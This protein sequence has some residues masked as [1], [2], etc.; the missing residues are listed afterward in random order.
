MIIIRQ[1]EIFKYLL[2]LDPK[3]DF[4]FKIFLFLLHNVN[5]WL[6]KK[7]IN[8]FTSVTLFFELICPLLVEQEFTH[9]IFIGI[10][11]ELKNV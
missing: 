9:H 2:P 10:S 6:K 8:T 7:V 3:M 1:L 11:L 5:P 4:S